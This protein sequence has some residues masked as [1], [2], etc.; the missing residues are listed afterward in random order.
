MVNGND[1]AW[2]AA[3]PHGPRAKPQVWESGARFQIPKKEQTV[4]RKSCSRSALIASG[5]ARGP[6]KNN[7]GL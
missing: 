5:T 1:C 6:S 3:F 2:L 7:A 4:N